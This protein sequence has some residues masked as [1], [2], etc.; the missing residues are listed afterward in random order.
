M[1]GDYDIYPWSRAQWWVERFTPEKYNEID[2][3][4]VQKRR[5][6]S[7]V[8]AG[9]WGYAFN[10]RKWPFDNKKVRYAFSYLY[11]REKFN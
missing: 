7:K 4:W 3:G 10:M 6:H 11:N 9:T 8:P 2:K 1:N 5:V